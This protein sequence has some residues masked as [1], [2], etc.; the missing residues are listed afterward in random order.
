MYVR[1]I[2][3]LDV[4]QLVWLYPLIVSG[5]GILTH[6]KNLNQVQ[7]T[8]QQQYSKIDE[9]QVTSVLMQARFIAHNI[10]I[11]MLCDKKNHNKVT[12]ICMCGI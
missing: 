11:K 4:L 7:L 5:H 8:V 12:C 1:Y 10:N 9:R 6:S 2:W 3:K